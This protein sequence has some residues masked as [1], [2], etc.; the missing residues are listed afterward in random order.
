[1]SNQ[2]TRRFNKINVC[3]QCVLRIHTHDSA[4]CN[5]FIVGLSSPQRL[6]ICDISIRTS[7]VKYFSNA[8]RFVNGYFIN[9]ETI[10]L[11]Y[12]SAFSIYQTTHNSL[13][14]TF[15]RRCTVFFKMVHI[16]VCI[17]LFFLTLCTA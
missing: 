7:R 16:S 1:M 12:N 17:F 10:V 9:C 13:F 2:Q 5:F 14:C 6:C 11:V 15:Q 8:W 3:A 4:H